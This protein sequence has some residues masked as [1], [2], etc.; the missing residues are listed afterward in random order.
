MFSVVFSYVGFELGFPEAA[1]FFAAFWAFV[2][3][4]VAPEFY[5]SFCHGWIG[6]TLGNIYF[7]FVVYTVLV[8]V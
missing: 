4:C 5:Y 2:F 8:I 3:V 7:S 1:E 6:N